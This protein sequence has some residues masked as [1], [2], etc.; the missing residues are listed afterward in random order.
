MWEAHGGG[1]GGD[2][3]AAET[4]AGGADLLRGQGEVAVTPQV[5]ELEGCDHHQ[6]ELRLRHHAVTHDV[7]VGTAL[8]ADAALAHDAA[9]WSAALEAEELN[10]GGGKHVR[11]GDRTRDRTSREGARVAK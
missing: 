8:V 10:V 5:R 9:K 11:H 6:A 3:V 4:L 1:K 7:L 2:T